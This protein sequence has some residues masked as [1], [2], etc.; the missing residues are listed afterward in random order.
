[1]KV[2]TDG[3]LLGAWATAV[4]GDSI[5]DIGCGTGLISLMMAQRFPGSRVTGV[6]VDV[7]AARQA[8][9]NVGASPFADR[10]GIEAADVRTFSGQYGAIVCNPPFFS[11]N[12]M[13]PDALRA[14][15]R[16]EQR[17]TFSQLWQSVDQML[18]PDGH[19]SVIIPCAERLRFQQEA[20][21]LGYS[22]EK[23]CVVC[24]TERKAPKRVMLCYVRGGCEGSEPERLVLQDEMGGR[25]QM[26]RELTDSFY[27]W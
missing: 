11:E 1:M 19:F 13:S 2:G 6:E 5:L 7:E 22:V 20:L 25:S 4:D 24:T 10:V 12:T 3:V 21:A 23:S 8:E 9:E 26:L 14:L 15:A 16:S 27:L 18:L 17:L